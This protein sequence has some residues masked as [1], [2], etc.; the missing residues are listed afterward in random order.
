MVLGYIY[1]SLGEIASHP[2]HP[3]SNCPGDFLTLI[4]YVGLLGSKIS[5]SQARHVFRDGRYLSLR[6][7]SYR[8]DS[9]NSG[10]VI[11]MGDLLASRARVSQSLSA[12]CFMIDIYKLWT[13]EICWLSSKIDEIFDVVETATKIEEL[14]D[15]DRFKALSDQDL[16]CSFE[17]AHIEGQLHSLSNET[18]ELKVKEQEILREEERIH[19]MREDLTIQQQSLIEAE[20]KLKSFLDLKKREAEQVQA[21]LVQAGFSKLQDLKKEKDHLKNLIG[22]VISFDND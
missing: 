15:V 6:A 17:I 11:D 18:S 20:S 13:I 21:D 10:D 7:S 9:C 14:V 1:H 3:D 16:T 8:V 2:Y 4:H 19:Q 12:L 5:L 22:F